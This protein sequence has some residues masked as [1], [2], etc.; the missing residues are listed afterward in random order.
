MAFRF[1]PTILLLLSAPLFADGASMLK[2]AVSFYYAHGAQALIK[3]ANSGKFHDSPAGYLLV[4]DRTGKVLIH[5]QS[6][7]YIGVNLSNFKDALGHAFVKE[8][9]DNRSKGQGRV[10]FVMNQGGTQVKKV[11]LWEY[12]GGVMFAWISDDH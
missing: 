1:R 2:E 7:Q 11:M 9:L 3:E 6:S 12:Q 5:G 8:A 10:N 4:L